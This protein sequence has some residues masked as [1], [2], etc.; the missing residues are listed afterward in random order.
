[1]AVLRNYIIALTTYT[2]MAYLSVKDVIVVLINLVNGNVNMSVLLA[3][4]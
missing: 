1:M 4:G 3:P 2:V